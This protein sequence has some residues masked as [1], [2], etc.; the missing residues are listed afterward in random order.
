MDAAEPS[1]SPIIPPPETIS[2][3]PP[4]QSPA[5]G[6]GKILPILNGPGTPE[7]ILKKVTQA[8][9]SSSEK[10]P[11][12][13]QQP[14]PTEQ[15]TPPDT[16][17]S[18]AK[19]IGIALTNRYKDPNDPNIVYEE[20]IEQDFQLIL[21]E[22]IKNTQGDVINSVNKQ[23]EAILTYP[24]WSQLTDQE[25]HSAEIIFRTTAIKNQIDLREKQQLP[26][27][28]QKEIE[29]LVDKPWFIESLQ[30][31]V[32]IDETYKQKLLLHNIDP[33]NI[34]KNLKS[35]K[36]PLAKVFNADTAF[37]TFTITSSLLPMLMQDLEGGERKRQ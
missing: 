6:E 29:T 22:K 21:A 28:H 24:V 26:T 27:I 9:I 3:T 19:K 1:P 33:N 2:S 32:E 15:N 36:G 5:Q 13:D 20:I 23:M 8:D 11:T 16:E 34:N 37:L 18:L 4:A 17:K 31:L 25:K 12:P 14:A 7:E 35:Q 30:R 10:T